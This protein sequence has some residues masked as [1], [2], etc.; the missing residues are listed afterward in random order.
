MRLEGAFVER[1][2][3]DDVLIA[4]L[5][6]RRVSV[7][8]IY[9]TASTL[10]RAYA[11]AG[12]PLVRV[13][14]PPQRLV[15][16]GSLRLVVVDG[17]IETVEVEGV[18]ARVR[19]IVAA[20]ATRLVGQRHLELAQL[21][22]ILLV[23]GGVPGLKLRSTLM[24][25]NRE[26]G[27]RL[28]LEGEHRLVTGS[29]GADDRL[30][31]SLGTWQLRGAVALNGAFG[32]GEQIYG[33]VGLGAN[34]RAATERAAPLAVYGGGLVVPIGIDG[35]TINPEYTHSTT[36]TAQAPG[37]VASYGTFERF[38]LRLREPI[39][40]THKSSLHANVSLEVIDQQIAAPDFGVTLSHDHYGVFRAGADF[41]TTLPWGSTIQLGGLWSG[42]LGG[43]S[44]TDAAASGVPLSR[45]GAG[46]DFAKLAGDLRISQALPAGLR[47]DVICIGQTTFG[48][49]IFRSEQI[50]LDGSD[51]I[52]AFA[53]GTF[54]ADQGATLRSE[55][56]RPFGINAFNTT[57][58]PYVFGAIGRGWLAN[59]TIVER[60]AFNAGAAG[61]GLRGNLDA[62]IST[63]SLA[64]E[65]ARGFTDLPGTR[66]GWRAN[67]I[68]A[69]AY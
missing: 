4:S 11:E 2:S 17:F 64:L 32:A 52:S 10:E 59:T 22:R 40:L 27:A 51:L 16:G 25:G 33:T 65:A 68:A 54:T 37:V 36:R 31:G 56:A 69:M 55:L 53:S 48:K 5:R 44:V 12:Y 63:A 46:P 57:V 1:A 21:E 30:P 41:S 20:R 60:P 62:G 28:I 61:L 39:V 45:L 7:A 9:A 23:A 14:V 67:V 15:D 26:G 3:A 13:A 43:R 49:P 42:G 8:Q 66:Q 47:W 50:S 35:L 38:A 6:G 34:L 24:R 19:S 18:P 29:A 58:S